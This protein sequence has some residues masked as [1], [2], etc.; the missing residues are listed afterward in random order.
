MYNFNSLV[1]QCKSLSLTGLSFVELA[2]IL[3]IETH[4]TNFIHSRELLCV[5]F[6]FSLFLTF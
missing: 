2:S 1:A 4:H 3:V 6:F 5:I